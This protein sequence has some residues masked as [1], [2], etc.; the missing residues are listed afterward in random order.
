[1]NCIIYIDLFFLWNFWMNVLIILVVRQLTK[2]FRTMRCLLAA[3]VGAIIACAGVMW[4]II[5]ETAMVL[6]LMELGGILVMNLLAFGGKNLL[7][8]LFLHS[9]ATVSIA[10]VFLYIL[11]I[12]PIE[13]NTVAILSVSMTAGIACILLEKK[14]RIRWKEE[15]MKVKTVMEFGDRKLF[16]TALMDTGNKLYDPFFHKPVI[17]VNEK[18]IKEML[19]RCREEYPEKL[20][21]IPFHSVGKENGVLEAM[22]FDCVNIKWQN[23]S[24]QFQNVIAASTK[25][26]LYK[27]KEYQVIFHCG[28]MEEG[29]GLYAD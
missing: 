7:W 16:A 23:K 2:T 15:H 27:G 20:H 18:I 8:H 12:L 1:M 3:A 4:Y 22:T 13:S 26:S 28:L 14:C 29:G 25:E 24:M 10:G 5:S 17:L 21:F 11:S 19:Q 6:L 9:I